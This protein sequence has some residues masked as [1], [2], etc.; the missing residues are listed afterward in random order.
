M[1]TLEKKDHIK[2][3]FSHTSLFYFYVSINEIRKHNTNKK[4]QQVNN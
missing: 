3:F 2:R 1:K 4:K